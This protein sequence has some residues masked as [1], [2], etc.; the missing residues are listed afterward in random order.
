M[1][2]KN[3]D[4]DLILTPWGNKDCL[5]QLSDN[6]MGHFLTASD[7][8]D[9]TS[10]FEKHL[11]LS[12][13]ENNLLTAIQIGNDYLSTDINTDEY[14][15]LC[16]AFF[17]FF[18]GYSYYWSRVGGPNFYMIRDNK[19]IPLSVNQDMS[20]N[21]TQ[22]NQAPPSLPYRYL[23]IKSKMDLEVL[24]LRVQPGDQ[25]IWM[26]ASVL[27]CQLN[28]AI[29]VSSSNE[30]LTGSIIRTNPNSSFWIYSKKIT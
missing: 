18:N 20:F 23:G 4:I 29:Q 14:I 27:P 1:F 2:S 25:L 9:G 22:Q 16:E 7:D 11:H 30:E 15:T 17:G 12:T 5:N 19:L 26:S 8:L 24:S 28:Q 6:I 10:P 3:E 21:Y 13:K